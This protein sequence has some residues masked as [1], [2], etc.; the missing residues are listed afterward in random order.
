MEEPLQVHTVEQSTVFPLEHI[1]NTKCSRAGVLDHRGNP[2][3]DSLLFR[4]RRGIR[5]QVI[6][7]SRLTDRREHVAGAALYMGP[8][9]TDFGHFLLEG[10]ARAWRAPTCP[11]LPLAWSID[12]ARQEPAYRP[13]QAEI[14]ELLG[15]S[16]RAIFVDTPTL[17]DQVIV[18]ESGYHIQNQFHPQHCDFLAVVDYR[19]EDQR[20]T[21]L[22][23]AKLPQKGNRTAELIDVR[24]AA[25]GWD[26]IHPESLPIQQQVA[27]LAA[28]ERVAGEQGAALHMLIFLKNAKRLRVDIIGRDSDL[29]LKS[30]NKNYVTIATAK[31]LNQT[32]HRCSFERFISRDGAIVDKIGQNSFKYLDCLGVPP[33]KQTSEFGTDPVPRGRKHAPSPTVARLRQLAKVNDSRSYLE[34]GVADGRTFLHIDFELKHAVDPRFRFDTRIHESDTTQFFETT[35]DDF[36]LYFARNDRTYDLIFLDGLHTFEQ[37]FRDFCSSQAHCHENTIWVIDD[38]FPSDPFSAVSDETKSRQFR[39]L[40][41]GSGK[42]PWHG[43]VFKTVFAINDFFPN[44]SFRTFSGEGNPQTVVVRRPRKDFVPKFDDLGEISR[45]NYLDFLECRDL[46]NLA[47]NDEVLAWLGECFSPGQLQSSA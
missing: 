23:R 27:Q 18:P 29:P 34:V 40:Q 31:Q 43:D 3:A 4:T 11:D 30:E 28:S 8:L 33:M 9:F 42:G 14:L 26:V 45:L 13:W 2:V 39:K 32:I 6:L 41:H 20:S 10:L 19:P 37:T 5:R 24:L 25:V 12:P 44:L 46:L 17:F 1:R 16:N 47:S 7:P 35:S 21:W 15:I 22:S 38:V 36:F